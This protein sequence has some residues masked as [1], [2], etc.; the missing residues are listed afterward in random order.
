MPTSRK[1]KAATAR[2]PKPAPKS[3]AL[4]KSKATRKAKPA[5]ATKTRAKAKP[6]PKI[7][8]ADI[9][10]FEQLLQQAPSGKRYEL[11][12]FI[13]GT[14][15]RS[16]QAIANIRSLCE[17]HLSGRYDLEVVDIY[18]QP[19]AASAEQIIAAPTLL[20]KFPLP[21]RRL[22]GDLS[23]RNKVLI[24]LNL[25]ATDAKAPAGTQW[26]KV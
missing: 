15:P 8:P 18:Q 24:G 17:E 5:P 4:P 10:T 1:S 20:K 7:D 19:G 6:A 11:R 22:V 25:A 9:A 3:K 16:A 2:R 14:T 26:I 12:L 13:T 21:S 23:D